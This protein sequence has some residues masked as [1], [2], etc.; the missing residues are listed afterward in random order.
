MLNSSLGLGFVLQAKD[1]TAPAFKSVRDKFAQVQTQARRLKSQSRDTFKGLF[2]VRGWERFRDSIRRAG[3]EIEK[4]RQRMQ[5]ARDLPPRNALG[6]FMSREQRGEHDYDPVKSAGLRI[7]AVGAIGLGAQLYAAK[8][9]GELT[10]ALSGLK[11]VS[12]ATA[13]EMARL[14]TVA[15]EM[16]RGTQ[17]S[18]SDV[19]TSLTDIASAG[20]NA[21]DSID[22]L[23]PS[24]DLATASLGQLSSSEAASVTA[25]TLKAFGIESKGAAPAVD[26]LVASMNL[27]AVQAKD[28]PLGLA[29]STRGAVALGQSLDETLVSFGLV[30]N[31]IPRVETAATAVSVA[32]ERMVDTGVQEE[33]R[34]MGVEAVDPLT[35]K[36]RPFLDIVSDLEPA[37]GKMSQSESAAWLQATF[38]SEA[39]TGLN[40][41]M[42]QMRSGVT[43]TGGEVLKGGAA[44]RYLREQ[45]AASEGTAADFAKEMSSGLAG[46]MRQLSGATKTVTQQIGEPIAEALKPL[47]DGA[48]GVVRRIGAE[49]DAMSPQ[50]KVTAARIALVAMAAVAAGGALT[51][52][53]AGL[54]IWRTGLAAAQAAGI[55]TSATMLPVVLVLAAIGIAAYGF[56]RAIDKNVGG[57]ADKLK[58]FADAAEWLKAKAL[59]VWDA[60]SQFAEGAADGFAVNVPILLDAFGELGSAISGFG[61][62]VFGAS[63]EAD[64]FRTTG[65]KVGTAVAK[66]VY[67]FTKLLTY[68]VR[69]ADFFFTGAAMAYRLVDALGLVNFVTEN[70]HTI[71]AG[72]IGLKVA[73]WGAAAAAGLSPLAV[74]V[75]LIT[76]AFLAVASAI[77]QAMKLYNEWDENSGSQLSNELQY[78]TGIIS[79]AEYSRRMNERQGIKSEYGTADTAVLDRNL[80]G[81]GARVYDRA[82]GGIFGGAA[83]RAADIARSQVAPAAP[84]PDMSKI[85]A[86]AGKLERAAASLS[87]QIRVDVSVEQQSQG[88]VS[89]AYNIE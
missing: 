67:L 41:I 69:L 18:A 50:A 20:Y 53:S 54:M 78:R 1:A 33:L 46:S 38:G 34:K 82:E 28:L 80:S 66:L 51:A 21:T 8:Q 45:M 49:L 10:D 37:L 72:V 81:E 9:S 5:T 76:A 57:S 17:Y 31:I 32:M 7:G 83:W 71:I 55:A 35:K 39:L 19:A 3:S 12:G 43:T 36:F 26:K 22:L 25:Q 73:S 29:N 30:K 6:Q 40:A 70:A 61:S 74:K 63:A 4:L 24:L 48:L 16:G 84:G 89:G 68:S 44:L 86:A 77:D 42:T 52:A 47:A 14:R 88:V 62:N 75:M 58:Q 2:E 27:F 87:K 59:A 85:D 15:L 13:D 60:V 65:Q 64:G 56:K 79:G 23:K 11:V